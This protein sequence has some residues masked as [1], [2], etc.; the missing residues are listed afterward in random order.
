MACRWKTIYK[1]TETVKKITVKKVIA[2][3]VLVIICVAAAAG[4]S[5]IVY[6]S[7]IKNSAPEVVKIDDE[8][9]LYYAEYTADYNNSIISNYIQAKWA[10]GCSAFV[11]TNADGDVITARNYDMYHKDT[12]GNF[13]GLNVVV[14]CNPD[15]GYESLATADAAW[16]KYLGYPYYQQAF[17]PETTDTRM[18]AFLPFLCMDGI[19]EKGLVVSI[20]ALDIKEGESPIN[21]KDS[22]KETLILTGLIRKLLDNCASV[23]E[24]VE[25]AKSVNVHN[26][27]GNDHHLLVSDDEGNSVVLEWRNNE[28]TVTDTDAVT[29]FYVSSD[30]ACDCYKNGELKEAWEGPADTEKEYH[31]G[32]GHGYERFKTIVTSLDEHGNED[33]LAVMENEE[34]MELL[35]EVAQKNLETVLDQVTQYSIIYNNT[36]RTMEIWSERDFDESYIF[37]ISEE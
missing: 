20:F 2:I 4:V 36:D 34:A 8:G 37:S 30:D 15:G 33:G 26:M 18:M 22:G 17:D 1:G 5:A 27:V 35:S 28:L 31:Y 10:S 9:F 23:E 16:I 12:D 32:Y 13:T 21:Q 11:A 14:R 19:N 24:A 6:N 25:Y 3:I 29:N 7:T